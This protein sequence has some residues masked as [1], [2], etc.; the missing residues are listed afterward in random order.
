MKPKPTM[1]HTVFHEIGRNF[2]F[3][4]KSADQFFVAILFENDIQPLKLTKQH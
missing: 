4:Q 1:K 3:S 2:L